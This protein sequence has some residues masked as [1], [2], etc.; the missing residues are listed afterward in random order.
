V[1]TPERIREDLCDR[2]TENPFV[3][4]SDVEVTISGSEVVLE[5]TVDSETSYLQTQAS[6]EEVIGVTHVHNH[7]AVRSKLDPAPTAGDAVNR[8]PGSRRR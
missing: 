4:A 1:R 5:G 7:L 8:M 2:L 3:D 6:A